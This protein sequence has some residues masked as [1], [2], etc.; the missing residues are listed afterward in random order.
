VGR[1]LLDL[2]Q[3]CHGLFVAGYATKAKYGFCRV[4]QQSTPEEATC[5]NLRPVGK[6]RHRDD[7]TDLLF[8]RFFLDGLLFHGLFLC[9]FLL[10][11]LLFDG[12]LFSSLFLAGY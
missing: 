12:F 2:A 3:P 9:C 4:G 5:C 1:A 6:N 8:S 10:R 7:L 11:S